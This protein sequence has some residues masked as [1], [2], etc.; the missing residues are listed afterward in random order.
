MK[1]FQHILFLMILLLTA[2]SCFQ[3]SSKVSLKLTSSFSFGGSNMAAFSEGGLM[4]WG[5][6]SKGKSFGRILSGTDDLSI[7]ID[8]DTWNFYSMAWDGNGDPLNARTKIRCGTINNLAVN[9]DVSEKLELTQAQCAQPIFAGQA[10]T[11]V[12]SRVR[13]KLCDQ[14]SVGMGFAGA[15]TNNRLAGNYKFDRAP[16]R[17]V[18]VTLEDHTNG[19][20]NGLGLSRC[21]PVPDG[22]SGEWTTPLA[23]ELVVPVGDSAGNNPFRLR[24][25]LFLATNDCTDPT[26]QQTLSF[27]TQGFGQNTD[28]RNYSTTGSAE[29]ALALAISSEDL[30][31]G[32][33][34]S[35]SP[36]AA[37]NGT[38]GAPYVI[39]SAAQFY[40]MLTESPSNSYLLASDIDLNFHSKG[41]NNPGNLSTGKA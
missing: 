9:G 20:P 16:V 37:G 12:G 19:V 32:G 35:L 36:F 8:N 2:Q 40:N 6:S 7:D 5:Q 18:R 41:I 33:R 27:V 10:P 11:L 26:M 4:V 21:V 13:L 24:T 34:A 3:K 14:I 39:C 22:E 31:A 1:Q 38:P 25:D 17:S 30:C 29:H 28:R 23:G 15:C